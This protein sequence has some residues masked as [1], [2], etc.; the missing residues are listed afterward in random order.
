MANDAAAKGEAMVSLAEAQ[1]QV[2]RVCKRLGLLHYAFA[3]TLMEE[4]GPARGRQL[5]MN[6]IKLYGTMIGQEVRQRVEA[7]GRDN[8]PENYG[9]D[10]PEYGMHE[11]REIVW[12][13]GEKRVRAYGCVMGKVWRELGVGELGRIYCC[14]DPAKYM[15]YN[16]GFKLIHLKLLPAGDDYCELAVRPTTAENRRDFAAP[17]T[18]LASLDR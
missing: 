12:V 17:D 7:Q 14:V 6:A 10:L 13:N 2:A 15:A 18:D 11:G 3:K 16:P 1:E 9:E 8:S 4:L 5:A